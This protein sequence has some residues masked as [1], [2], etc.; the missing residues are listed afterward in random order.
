MPLPLPWFNGGIDPLLPNVREGVAYAYDEYGTYDVLFCTRTS[1]RLRS[2]INTLSL[3]SPFFKYPAILIDRFTPYNYKW[4][5][6]FS[7]KLYNSIKKYSGTDYYD[8]D[9][10]VR[11]GDS[12]LNF[13]NEQLNIDFSGWDLRDSFD[14]EIPASEVEE[15]ISLSWLV[16]DESGSG[17]CFS[18]RIKTISTSTQARKVRVDFKNLVPCSLVI[19][20]T[21]LDLENAIYTQLPSLSYDFRNLEQLFL[22]LENAINTGFPRLYKVPL[23]WD[24]KISASIEDITSENASIHNSRYYDVEFKWLGFSFR[25]RPSYYR[26]CALFYANNDY[27]GNG[28]ILESVGNTPVYA[29]DGTEALLLPP[30]GKWMR[31]LRYFYGTKSA[32]RN[33][34][35][36]IRV[37]VWSGNPN[38]EELLPEPLLSGVPG[39]EVSGIATSNEYCEFPALVFKNFVV[40][41]S[42]APQPDWELPSIAPMVGGLNKTVHGHPYLL[43]HVSYDFWEVREPLVCLFV[44]RTTRKHYA[45]ASRTFLFWKSSSSWHERDSFDPISKIVDRSALIEPGIEADKKIG[46]GDTWEREDS[47]VFEYY[48]SEESIPIPEGYTLND[49]QFIQVTDQETHYLFDPDTGESIELMPD[50]IRVKEIHAALNAHKY[51]VDENDPSKGRIANLGYYT[52]RI[53]RVLGISVK[54]D[55]SIKSIEQK[56]SAPDGS[57]VPAGWNFGQFGTRGSGDDL[58]DGIV[59]EERC[60]NMSAG[61]FDPASTTISG[62]NLVLCENIPQYIDALLDD[63]DKALDWQSLGAMVI[64]S[65]QNDGRVA[66]M[67]GI[68]AALSEMLYMLS[69]IH[70]GTVQNQ[71]SSLITQG[72]NYELL[73]STGQPMATKIAKVNVSGDESLD[74]AYPGLAEDNLSQVTQTAMILKNISL[75]LGSLASSGKEVKDYDPGE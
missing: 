62:G 23:K 71:V 7:T 57:T 55:G 75:L 4:C 28:E 64:P 36:D 21:N 49:E 72:T 58:R 33:G 24:Y 74:I 60:N 40:G 10:F 48:D 37:P 63:L 59:Y 70:H 13:G 39:G 1:N 73:K 32:P 16:I 29:V 27:W 68:G 54:A 53:A 5:S 69:A 22:K 46:V 61:K 25:D 67:E 38:L 52:E 15:V 45:S 3:L 11:R 50:S 30:A 14:F 43:A 44:S 26:S 17:Q 65:F 35:V 6:G 20:A 42:A 34:Q 19:S 41:A 18:K 12:S 9:D 47:F 8:R 66:N 2:Q 56:R 51:G 31:K